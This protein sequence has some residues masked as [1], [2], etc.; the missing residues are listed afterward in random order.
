MFNKCFDDTPDSQLSSSIDLVG[1]VEARMIKIM[2]DTS[3]QKNTEV[4]LG[5]RVLKTTSM[6]ENIPE[7]RPI[8]DQLIITNQILHHLCDAESVSEVM[9]WIV[10]IVLLNTKQEPLQC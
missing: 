3:C 9:E 6:N 5:E 7:D 8:R 1:V 4:T 10:P 2:A